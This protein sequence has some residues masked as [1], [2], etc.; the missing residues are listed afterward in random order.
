ML[1]VETDIMATDQKANGSRICPALT[2][3]IAVTQTSDDSIPWLGTARLR[4]GVALGPAFIYGTGGA[5]YGAFKST[6]TLTTALASVTSTTQE[7]RLAW[8][9]GGGVELALS[10]R[11]SVRAEYLHIDAGSNTTTYSL[12]G[13][14]LITGQSRMTEDI[15][16]F[17]I[18]F[19]Y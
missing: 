4:A 16:R 10:D 15:G 18:N 5:G 12:A 14:S 7:Q 11:W 1:G 13:V 19:R 2:C 6:Q 9:A 8:V 3:G 17:G